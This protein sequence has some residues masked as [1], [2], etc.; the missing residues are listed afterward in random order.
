MGKV[1]FTF[2]EVKNLLGSMLSDISKRV[3]LTV[4]A[5][6]DTF[7]PEFKITNWGNK[8]AVL[9]YSLKD[10][11]DTKLGKRT[12]SLAFELDY[13]KIRDVLVINWGLVKLEESEGVSTYQ[14]DNFEIAEQEPKTDEDPFCRF[15]AIKK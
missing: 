6:P 7:K 14:I 8:E 10:E 12:V 3:Q 2:G 1:S 9:T 5:H 4:N 11:M 15:T 13:Q